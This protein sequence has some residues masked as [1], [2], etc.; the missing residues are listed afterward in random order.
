MNF[1]SHIGYSF[2][3]YPQ[4]RFVCACFVVAAGVFFSLIWTA[5]K[6]K[7]PEITAISPAAAN[8]EEI[9]SISGKNFG[10]TQKDSYVEISGSRLTVS[11]Y[12]AWNDTLIKI[13][14]PPNIQDGLIYVVTANGRSEPRI[15]ANKA[16]V[17]VPVPQGTQTSLP[18]IT[19]LKEKTGTIGGILTIEGIN[20]GTLRST[21]KVYFPLPEEQ[22][23]GETAFH[24]NPGGMYDF[25]NNQ[26]IRVRIPDGTCSG[27]IYVETP[28][29]KSN[30]FQLDIVNMPGTKRF[31]DKRIYL[32]SASIDI[33]DIDAPPNSAITIRFPK[34]A[35]TASQ[36][37]VSV[38]ASSEEPLFSDYMNTIVHQIMAPQG[39]NARNV[40]IS[41]SHSFVVTAH[42][43]ATTIQQRQVKDYSEQT[44]AL[45]RQYLDE[46]TDIPANN[47]DIIAMSRTI[48]GQE[49]N[50]YQKAKLLYNWITENC[51]AV[52]GRSR[53]NK[54]ATDFID[55][56]EGDSYDFAMAFCALARAS[57][58]PTVPNAGILIDAAMKSKNHWW[59]EFYIENFGWIPA[60][61]ALG[62]G[63]D[64]EA[65]QKKEDGKAF[66]FGN[67][68]AQ[69]IVFSRGWNHHQQMIN[70]GKT[71]YHPK[72]YALQSIWEE[73]SP[74]IK[75]YSSYWSDIYIMGIY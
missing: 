3:K 53:K 51:T 34:P 29:G 45:Y 54:S 57:G 11:R 55:T 31:S 26:E 70:D 65:F 35:V 22:T 18:V 67:I 49:K 50:P 27:M 71:V 40:K 21:S 7:P 33:T 48:I 62:A 16:A 12:A 39:K 9:L 5:D 38:T 24:S 43:V 15:F 4:I 36:T 74:D 73:S 63:F 52:S 25:W 37:D 23:S 46:E 1:F 6:K 2:R 72:M 69:H 20:F 44:L 8:P 75:K 64:Y 41:I 58:I 32:L 47:E 59:C 19:G 61:P 14:L 56:K 17:P 42:A 60:D 13:Q 68:D 28:K 10:E 66:Y 30:E